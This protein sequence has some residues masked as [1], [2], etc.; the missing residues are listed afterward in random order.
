MLGH[1]FRQ[2]NNMSPAGIAWSHRVPRAQSKCLSEKRRLELPGFLGKGGE[3]VWGM[4]V[5][6]R[7]LLLRQW[8]S[9]SPAPF[10]GFRPRGFGGRL[11]HPRYA[12]LCNSRRRQVMRTGSENG[13]LAVNVLDIDAVTNSFL[14]VHWSEKK[15]KG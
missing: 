11:F 3:A 6:R 10:A 13:S 15:E 1:A 12:A 2:V 9:W 7:L 5:E 4:M 8:E 14:G